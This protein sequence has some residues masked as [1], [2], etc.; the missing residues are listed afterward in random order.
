MRKIQILLALLCASFACYAQLATDRAAARFLD[1]AAFGPTPVGILD[2]KQI[3]IETWIYWQQ[4]ITW[5]E[6]PDQPLLNAAGNVNGDLAPVR[7]AFFENAAYMPDQ[8]RQRV[9]LALSEIWVVSQVSTRPAYAYPP[10]W[11]IFRDHAFGNYRD[12]IRA[13]TLSPAMGNFLNMAN[14]NKASATRAANENYA[15]ELLQLFTLGLVQLNMDGT[16]VR[17]AGGKTVA[18]YDQ[19]AI[20]NLSRALTGWTYPLAPGATARNNNPAYYLGEMYAVAANHDTTAKTIFGG[21]T[22]PAGQTAEQDLESVIDALMAQ[23][24]MAPFISRQLIQHL[25]TSNPSPQYVERIANVFWDNGRGV[26]GDLEAVVRAI[27]LDPE[28]RA[29]DD[30][31]SPLQPGFGKMREPVLFMANLI[32][33]LTGTTTETSNLNRFAASMGQDLFNAP[34]VFSYFSPG[35]RVEGLPAPEF[36][37]YNTQS[38]AARANIVNAVL[39]GRLEAGTT[40]DLGNYTSKAAVSVDALVDGIDYML[41]H[42]SM[43]PEVNDA[44]R[45]AVAR[46]TGTGAALALNR[47]RAALYVALTAAQYQII[48]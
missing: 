38:A 34:S 43:P 47:T 36:Q 26:R 8:L 30:P 5:S 4:H 32:R 41:F 16:P 33:N 25:V 3:G 39:Y 12:L 23:R 48:H 35:Y 11:R 13:V 46:Q 15:R 6:L 40:F 24:T 20:T 28:A 9:A 7:R 44:I 17:D 27:L 45:Y 37:L 29:G 2:V 14:N 1:Q 22:I 42:R 18:T 19:D 10:Y 21:V 31:A